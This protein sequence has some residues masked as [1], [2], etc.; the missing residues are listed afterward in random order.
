VT[1]LSKFIG[2]SR[3]ISRRAS[4]SGDNPPIRAKDQQSPRRNFFHA[5]LCHLFHLNAW[6]VHN[7][8]FV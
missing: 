2:T 7:L 3:D 6:L 8:K 5:Y 1:I 4:N